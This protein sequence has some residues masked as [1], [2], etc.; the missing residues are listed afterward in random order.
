M[1]VGHPPPVATVVRVEKPGSNGRPPTSACP[2]PDRGIVREI[3]EG[4]M[5]R[6]FG[7]S[8]SAS[9]LAFAITVLSALPAGPASRNADTENAVRA[10]QA[11]LTQA[12]AV[13]NDAR[14]AEKKARNAAAKTKVR[15]AVVEAERRAAEAAVAVARARARNELDPAQAAAP[16]A[17]SP[18]SLIHA[19]IDV[20][21]AEQDFARAVDARAAAERKAAEVIRALAHELAQAAEQRQGVVATD[22]AAERR[23][24]LAD[25]EAMETRIKTDVHAATIPAARAQA[26]EAEAR[27]RLD[28]AR[29]REAEVRTAIENSLRAETR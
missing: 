11:A 8:M 13:L 7:P 9:V 5:A 21:A 4:A 24:Q 26:G 28:V 16:G 2:R 1:R 25:I 17:V 27:A 29:R 3:R 19:R 22:S 14:A 6:P 23:R 12:E 18:E 20:E 10:A 15:A